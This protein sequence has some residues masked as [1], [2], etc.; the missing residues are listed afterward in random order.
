[1]AS[2]GNLGRD[3]IEPGSDRVFAVPLPDAA[4]GIT[5]STFTVF[6]NVPV[7][8]ATPR[9][10][11]CT[12]IIVVSRK[13][14]WANHMWEIPGFMPEK[15]YVPVSDDGAGGDSGDDISDSDASGFAG[16]KWSG[17]WYLPGSTTE[18]VPQF[19][20]AEQRAF[21][22]KHILD[23]LHAP[24]DPPTPHH[25]KGL[26]EL[27]QPGNVFD[28]GSEPQVFMFAP[29]VAPRRGEG[30]FREENPV[31]LPA[32]FDLPGR[33]DTERADEGGPSFNDQ[34]RSELRSIFG[35]ALDIKMVHYAPDIVG[36]PLDESFDNPRG[37][38][39]IQYEPG[40]GS[41]CEGAE[42]RWRVFFERSLEP[43]TE[44]TWAPAD[45]QYCL[46][47][48]EGDAQ[49]RLLRRQAC[50]VEESQPSTLTP[51]PTHTP[52]PTLGPVTELDTREGSSCASTVTV[53]QCNRAACVPM[54]S[55]AS[56]VA[57]AAATPTAT[58]Q[59]QVTSL[60]VN[61]WNESELPGHADIDSGDMITGA[62]KFCESEDAPETMDASSEPYVLKWTNKH[63]V[64][65]DYQV[66]WVEGCVT[67]SE[68]QNVQYPTKT[69]PNCI[70]SLG[71]TY[72][73]CN[74][75]GIGGSITQGCLVYEF[76]G[77][78]SDN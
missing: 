21:F 1:M 15:E 18:V 25:V 71:R 39:L 30:Q 77:G 55:C 33:T 19:P 23:T 4:A 9:L 56:W 57:T 11:G 5:S 17:N 66:Y 70:S 20:A 54:P 6:G 38:A 59:P 42:A 43:H 16:E 29:Y 76:M 13:G 36:D 8:L 63:D 32:A 45:G 34:I 44:E 48:G 65:Y 73:K 51:S 46:P 74:N 10:V 3:S 75:G 12:T 67:D 64:N 37:R 72:D 28:D 62:Q 58:M 68:S 27:R 22:Q 78:R 61:C 7:T 2:E 26:D 24:Y 40:D 60:P 49:N 47:P 69:G 14:T 52:V 35:E 50:G 41:D 53:D 31:G